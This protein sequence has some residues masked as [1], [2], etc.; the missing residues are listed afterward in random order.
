MRMYL[1]MKDFINSN[2][3]DI[4]FIGEKLTHNKLL[5][6]KQAILNNKLSL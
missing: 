3:Y 5:L 6:F 4:G 2:I 1:I